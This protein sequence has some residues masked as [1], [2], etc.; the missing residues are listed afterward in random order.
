MKFCA[1]C[2][3]A[4]IF[5]PIFKFLSAACV[6]AFFQYYNRF[7]NR[8]REWFGGITSIGER[9]SQKIVGGQR[10]KDHFTENVFF[11]KFGSIS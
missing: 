6:P 4:D 11:I 10:S 3:F 8:A 1:L 7:Q 5:A 9:S 2:D